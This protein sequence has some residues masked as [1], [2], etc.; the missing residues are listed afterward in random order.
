MHGPPPPTFPRH[1]SRLACRPVRFTAPRLGF[2]LIDR[3]HARIAAEVRV[4][5]AAVKHG[6]P[7]C[8]ALGRLIRDSGRHFATEDRLMRLVGY[9]EE[10]GH[11]ALHE[12]VMSEMLRMRAMLLAGQP[13]HPR[14]AEQ[15]FEWLLHH[16]A[17]ADRNLVA[18]LARR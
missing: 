11:R 7:A 9:A 4:L 16:T 6:R 5:H 3:Q 2:A 1:P 12:G 13:L 14:H 17:E 10:A 18:R 8:A 15:I